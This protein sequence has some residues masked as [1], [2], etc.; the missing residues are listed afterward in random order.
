MA[1]GTTHNYQLKV[2]LSNGNSVTAG[3]IAVK[4]GDTP[5]LSTS[6]GTSTTNGYTQ[7]YINS[8]VSSL[9]GRI[10]KITYNGTTTY[11]LNLTVDGTTL[12][13]ETT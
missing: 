10:P 5:E 9:S 12:I 7:S 2:G 11:K 6:A 8:Q 3:T 1:T 13:I 4:D